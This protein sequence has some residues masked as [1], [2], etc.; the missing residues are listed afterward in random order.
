MS[1][2]RTTP[3]K[4]WSIEHHKCT[5]DVRREKLQSVPFFSHLSN[6]QLIDIDSSFSAHHKK[7]GDIIYQQDEPAIY[8]RILVYGSLRLMHHTEEGKDILI[9]LLKPGEYF[10]TL[11]IL[12]DD[13]YQETA[14]AHTDCCILSITQRGL[15]QILHE[16]PSVAVKMIEVT[17]KKLKTARNTIRNLNN[18]SIEERVASILLLLTEK[19]GET[20]NGRTLIQIPLSRKNI[21]DMAGTATETISR[22]MST[23][24]KNGWVESG[25]KWILVSNSTALSTIVDG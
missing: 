21:A 18:S 11:P 2:R 23:F 5:P 19:F 15:N 10:G 14:Y 17:A 13:T 6:E 22:V 16:Q 20:K 4:N 12:G 25:R 24:Q 8:L 3:L 7:N 1:Q 9:D